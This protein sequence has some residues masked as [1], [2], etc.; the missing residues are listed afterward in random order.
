MGRGREITGKG[1]GGVE[2][3]KG[4]ASS[5]KICYVHETPTSGEAVNCPRQS[6][7]R[8]FRE[9]LGRFKGI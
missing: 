1:K 3:F 4:G 9:L 7:L 5:M 6:V 8:E 2:V